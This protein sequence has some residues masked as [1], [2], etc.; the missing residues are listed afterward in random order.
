[1]KT[2]PSYFS[3]YLIAL[4]V[5]VCTLVLLGAL[6]MTLTGFRLGK[7]SRV[8]ELDFPD[9]AG[10]HQ[11]SQVRYAGAPAGSVISIRHLT[12][13]E[14]LRNPNPANAVRVTVGLDAEVPQIPA[15]V[16]AVLGADTLLS[17]KFIGL[18]AGTAGGPMLA[19]GA[20]VQGVAQP[21]FDELVRGGADVFAALNGILPEVKSRMD[22]ILPKLASISDAGSKVADDAKE[23]FAKAGGLIDDLKALSKS[24]N[25]LLSG[26][27]KRLLGSANEIAD[28]AKS[29]I[30]GADKLL[31]AHQADLEK[32]LD[33]L[34]EVLDHMDALLGRTQ[35]LLST[36][37][38]DLTITIRDLRLLMQEMRVMTVD[39]GKVMA[40]LAKGH[41]TR[42]IWTREDE[43]A[44][45]A[46]QGQPSASAPRGAAGKR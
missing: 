32:A 5:I 42:L 26:D 14:R 20:V 33:E 27:A 22:E 45:G 35:G 40:T 24:G 8:L 4:T 41:P 46:T 17:E 37:E 15:D 7:P 36:N 31:E 10:I 6:A 38:K 43:P 13:D 25:E 12:T 16:S 18:T 11:H 23:L 1:M 29:L 28:D 21:T 30:G 3:D 39:A 19:D 34:P 9:V 44:Q 2:R